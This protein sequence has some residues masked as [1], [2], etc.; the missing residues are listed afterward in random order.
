MTMSSSTL[1]T[2]VGEG[3]VRR[4]EYES[5]WLTRNRTLGLLRSMSAFTV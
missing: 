1:H 4:S 2:G 5:S 3:K